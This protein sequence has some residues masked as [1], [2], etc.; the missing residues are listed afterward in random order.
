MSFGPIR[1]LPATAGFSLIASASPCPLQG[2]FFSRE[3]GRTDAAGALPSRCTDRPGHP[4]PRSPDKHTEPRGSGLRRHHQQPHSPRLHR[5]QG[6]RQDLGH[7]P[8]GQQ[9]SS[10]PAGL[11]GMVTDVWLSCVIRATRR[12]VQTCGVIFLNI[13]CSLTP[14]PPAPRRQT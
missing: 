11:P 7:Q 2:L 14:H 9:E 4:T 3:C 1:T 12:L 8:A 10:V 6:L 5:W 13:K